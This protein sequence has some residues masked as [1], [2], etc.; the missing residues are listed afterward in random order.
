MTTAAR[1]TPEPLRGEQAASDFPGRAIAGACVLA[2]PVLILMADVA[3]AFVRGWWP[4]ANLE[5]LAIDV[6]LFWLALVV[7]VFTWGKGRRFLVTHFPQLVLLVASCSIVLL[8]VDLAL[9]PILAV[10]SDPMHGRRPGFEVTYRPQQAIMRGV[11]PT[12]HVRYNAWGVR[13]SDPPPRP[14]AYRIVCIGGSSTACTYLDDEKTWPHLIAEYLDEADAGQ[15][16]WIG[17]AGI[18]G[19][20]AAEHLR[21]AN[22]SP[23]MSE[24]DC[25]VVQAGINDYMTCLAGPKP[26]PPAWT[27]LQLW[28]LA[29]NLSRRFSES[30]TSVEDNAG[31]VYQRRRALRAKA[32]LSDAQPDLAGC[33]ADYTEKLRELVAVCQRRKVR[34]VLTTQPTLWRESMEDAERALLW[35]GQLPD[36]RY[37]SLEQLRRGMDRYNEAVRTVC[38]ETGAE[39]VE[40]SELDGDSSAFYDDCHLTETGARRVAQRV[41]AGLAK[42][43]A[44]PDVAES[45]T[46]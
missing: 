5:A 25:L 23:V 9:G 28:Q 37:L 14:A 45:Q 33:L 15:K 4:D 11:G 38:R 20:Q 21:F 19:Y 46:P 6:L 36:G 40:L 34:V 29:K 2:A 16:H 24:I 30:G 31:T 12:A 44:K 42:L 18:P 35:F 7:L 41:A 39:F 17:N 32:E 13:G 26:A 3:S 43:P 10:V 1:T 8:A 27:K 22:E